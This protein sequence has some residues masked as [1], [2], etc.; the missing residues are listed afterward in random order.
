VAWTIPL[1]ITEAKNRLLLPEKLRS[2][3][4]PC[5]QL[6]LIAK[7]RF[8]PLPLLKW[9]RSKYAAVAADKLAPAALK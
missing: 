3:A 4:Y 7:A 2:S 1:K 9:R 8:M 6:H 5:R